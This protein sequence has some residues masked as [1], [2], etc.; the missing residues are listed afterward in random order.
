MVEHEVESVADEIVNVEGVNNNILDNV[1]DA[2]GN[3]NDKHWQIVERL[4]EIMLEEKTSDGIM[5]KKV[6]KDIEGS[7]R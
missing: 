5:F 7:S 1:D 2:R 4:N 6:G 3:L